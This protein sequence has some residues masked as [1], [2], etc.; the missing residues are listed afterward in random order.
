M[1]TC[2]HWLYTVNSSADIAIQ[3]IQ[4]KMFNSLAQKKSFYCV[5]TCIIGFFSPL[6][7]DL[8]VSSFCLSYLE[9]S[10]S[11]VFSSLGLLLLRLK[12]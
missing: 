2:Y 8:L 9:S 10:S 4:Y 3:Y 5:L 7:I 12:Y 11:P 6:S 1:T